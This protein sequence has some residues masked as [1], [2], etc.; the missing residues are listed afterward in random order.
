MGIILV[1][2][3]S[4]MTILGVLS[5]WYAAH[6][7]GLV[8]TTRTLAII[9]IIG[10]LF[11]FGYVYKKG[12]SNNRPN[13][14]TTTSQKTN[15]SSNQYFAQKNSESASIAQQHQNEQSILKQLNKSYN[16]NVGQVTFDQATKTYTVTPTKASYIK[17]V[18]IMWNYPKTN[19]KS[20][21]SM[22]TNYVK[23]SKSID[24]SLKGSYTL[25]VKKSQ[26]G[27]VILKIKNGQAQVLNEGTE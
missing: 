3:F 25:Q 24:K 10:L 7:N 27:P 13:S 17:S 19:A 18:T 23:M 9:S 16:T 14:Q 22:K 15:V 26:K 5:W 11:S 2:I 20:I 8:G 6:Y 12:W 21:N 1:F 4:I